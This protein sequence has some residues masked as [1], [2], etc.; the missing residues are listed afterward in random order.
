MPQWAKH[1]V[2][3]SLEAPAPGPPLGGGTAEVRL[4]SGP[5]ALLVT[6]DL[7][8]GARQRCL[9]SSP[10]NGKPYHKKKTVISIDMGAPHSWIVFV[11]ENPSMDDWWYPYWWKPP[12]G[13]CS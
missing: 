12:N 8:A 9:G 3:P 10:P 2:P 1:H 4:G 11:R 7:P 13:D 6:Q 5:R